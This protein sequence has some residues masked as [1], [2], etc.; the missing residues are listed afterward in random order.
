M[1]KYFVNLFKPKLIGPP[2]AAPCRLK[3]TFVRPVCS[4][5]FFVQFFRIDSNRTG[6]DGFPFMIHQPHAI[7]QMK[8]DISFDRLY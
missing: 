7:H 8:D 2:Q 4:I 1:N 3:A 5:Y 6:V